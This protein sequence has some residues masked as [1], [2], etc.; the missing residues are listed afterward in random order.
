M[1][2]LKRGII[3][4]LVKKIIS[5]LSDLVLFIRAIPAVLV[6]YLQRD[7]ELILKD[8]YR[9]KEIHN[10][11]GNIYSVLI[12]LLP[13]YKAFRNIYYMRVKK[14]SNFI[15][16]LL[17]IFYRPPSSL[18]IGEI[19]IGGGLYIQH[20][21]STI[22]GAKEIGENCWINQQV[23]IGYSDHGNPIIKD[24]VYIYAGAKV[25]GDIMVNSNCK[26]GANAVVVK[27]VPQNCTAVGVPAKYLS[28][29][30]N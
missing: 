6:L 30:N 21:F 13:R 20:G 26:I 7:N 24:N 8:I 28:L 10:L 3:V 11:D 12:Y 1:F 15:S 19:E 17:A 25:I 4:K 27:D 18:Y 22:I 16:K 23:T 14:K 9:W 29:N 5:K 2:I